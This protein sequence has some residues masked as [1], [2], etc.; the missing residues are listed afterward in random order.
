MIRIGDS[1]KIFNFDEA[2]AR[3]AFEGTAVVVGFAKCG[4]ANRYIVRFDHGVTG[5]RRIDPVAQLLDAQTFL[6]IVNGAISDLG[7]HP[8]AEQRPEMPPKRSDDLS[9]DQND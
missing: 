6:A 2:Q 1:V 4:I 7:A 3:I 5:E 9:I 8:L